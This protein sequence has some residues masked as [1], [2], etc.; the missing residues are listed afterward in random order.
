[1]K[2]PA[3]TFPTMNP[4][5]AFLV[6]SLLVGS[7]LAEALPATFLFSDRT[8]VNGKVRSIDPE[9]ETMVIDSESLG[10]DVSLLSGRLLEMVFSQEATNERPDYIAIATTTGHYNDQHRDTIKGRLVDLNEEQVVLDT[11][12]AGRLTLR[13]SMLTSLEIFDETPGFYQGPNGPEGWVS[14]SGKFEDAWIFE[15]RSMASI[16]ST[17]IARQV[18]F[19]EMTQLSFTAKWKENPYFR[20]MFYSNDGKTDNPQQGYMLNVQR[21][22][23]SIYRRDPRRGGDSVLGES[24]PQLREAEQA[25]FTFYLNRAKGGTNALFIDGVQV[26]TWSADNDANYQG[27]W[28][29]FVPGNSEPFRVSNL[30]VKNWDGIMPA[31]VEEETSDPEIEKEELKG[32][33]VRLVNGDVVVGEVKKI[34]ED[35]MEL[36]TSFGDVLVPVKAVNN[37]NL[38]SQ[39]EEVRQMRGDV[40]AWFSDGGYMTIQ[41]KA[42]DGKTLKGYSQ[43]WGEADFDI[44]AFQRVEFNIWRRDLDPARFDVDARW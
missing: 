10:N 24:I 11:W 19:P 20:L 5:P 26:G 17:G 1:M 15:N 22:Y 4:L 2:L 35:L 16:G 42:F 6:S 29:H 27:N 23:L 31:A 28:L 39:E 30:S 40:R 18:D 25:E 34:T 14:S 9:A 13:R 21:S 12:Y 8:F 41:L 33:E 44:A 36:E 37:I 38:Q 3:H 43:V 7:L 32:Q